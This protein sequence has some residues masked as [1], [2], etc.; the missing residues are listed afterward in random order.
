M[1]GTWTLFFILLSSSLIPLSILLNQNFVCLFLSQSFKGFS[2]IHLVRLFL[3]S[4]LLILHAFTHFS[5]FSQKFQTKEILGFLTFF[6]VLIKF[7]GWVFVHA[8]C[9]HDSHALISKIS[10]FLQNFEIRVYVFL[11]NLEILFNWVKLI[12]IDLWY[13]LIEWL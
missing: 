11:R 13:C 3:P 2:P 9:K 1:R 12:K 7:L 10:W 8:S 5:S 6:M 4:F